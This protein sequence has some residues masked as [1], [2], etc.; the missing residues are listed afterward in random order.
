[1]FKGFIIH[2]REGTTSQ[3][4]DLKKK[5]ALWLATEVFE[6]HFGFWSRFDLG[7][8]WIGLGHLQSFLRRLASGATLLPYLEE[9]LDP[10]IQNAA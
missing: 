6:N 3:G 9:L 2:S 5:K 8:K 7:C 10:G 1:M 4:M